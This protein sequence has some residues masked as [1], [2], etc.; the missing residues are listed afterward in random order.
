MQSALLKNLLR[1]EA[2]ACQLASGLTQPLF[3]GYALYGQYELRKGRHEELAT[4]YR[5]Q[6]LSAL[7][8]VENALVAARE[9]DRQVRRQAESDTA[10]RRALATALARLRQGTIDSVTLAITQTSLFQSQ[11]R[12]AQA[13]LALPDS[14]QPL[15][16]AWRRLVADD[17]RHRNRAGERSLR[18]R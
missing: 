18:S 10:W 1:P 2:V 7:T 14:D 16:G 6:I 8:D 13:R 4:L 3:D 17:P 11:D 12:L 9:T 5:K 15:S